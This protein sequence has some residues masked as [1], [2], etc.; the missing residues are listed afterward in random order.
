LR[1]RLDPAAA[2]EALNPSANLQAVLLAVGE[3]LLTNDSGARDI[4]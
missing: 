3:S 4:D 2:D 1:D